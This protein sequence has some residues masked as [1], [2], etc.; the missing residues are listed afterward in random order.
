MGAVGIPGVLMPSPSRGDLG[1][2]QHLHGAGMSPSTRGCRDGLGPFPCQSSRH[3]AGA[4]PAVK[5]S[6]WDQ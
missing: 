5:G 3:R 2:A 6:Q 4:E 1:S